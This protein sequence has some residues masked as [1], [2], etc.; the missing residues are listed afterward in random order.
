MT[1]CYNHE[2]LQ[3]LCDENKLILK[4][5]YFIVPVNVNTVIEGKCKTEDC[6]K[7]FSKRFRYLVKV[8]GY[9]TE[10]SRNR[11]KIKIVETC[12]E[13]Y[14]VKSAKQSN[15]VKEKTKNTF[16]KK[17]GVENPN[18][19]KEV[20]DKIK[21]TCLEKYGVENPNQCKEVRNKM[22]KTCLEKYGVENISQHPDF[23]EKIKQN[24]LKK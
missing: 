23:S 17:Y 1:N 21:K 13:R 9:C 12:L 20:R 10:C 22:K 3:K 7:D 11:G 4:E 8:G 5:D 19:L 24:N 14:G 6:G 18:Q 15:E 2:T 16:L